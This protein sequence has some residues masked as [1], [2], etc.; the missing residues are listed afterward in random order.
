[1]NKGPNTPDQTYEYHLKHYGPHVVYDDFIQNFTASSYN[2][3]DWVDL[4]AAAG[5]QYFVPVSKHHDGYAIFDLP[6]NVT[7][8]T[9]VAPPPH[10]DLLQELFDAAAQYQP[11][12]HRATSYSLPEWFHLDYRKYGFAL[13]LGGNATNPFTNETL[14]YTGYVPVQDYITDVIV[15]EMNAL[16]NMGT[17]IMWCTH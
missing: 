13:W 4:F 2:P 1:L 12:L 15:P 17:E 9:S 16:A 5:A 7:K 8:R 10:R 6:T 11:H 14:P 3:R